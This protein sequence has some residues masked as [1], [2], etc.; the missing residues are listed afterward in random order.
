MALA[1]GHQVRYI[2]LEPGAIFNKGI[3]FLCGLKL[4]ALNIFCEEDLQQ[5]LC[6]ML[7][8]AWNISVKDVPIDDYGLLNIQTR[9]FRA[10][11]AE[12]APNL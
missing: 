3:G 7:P 8:I 9:S 5:S 10:V 11:G 2:L 12:A 4:L 1:T 6:L